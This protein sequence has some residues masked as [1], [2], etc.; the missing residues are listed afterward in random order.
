MIGNW[1]ILNLSEPM[2]YIEYAK[3]Y[4]QASIAM[5][6]RMKENESHCTWSNACVVMMLASH[7]V[8]LFLKGAILAKKSTAN[9]GNHHL[10]YLNAI[11]RETYSDPKYHFEVPFKT[12]CLGMTD[13]E[14]EALKKD[15]PQPSI[16]F[17][18][19][20]WK[21]GVEWEGVYG[22]EPQGFLSLLDSLR[23]NYDRVLAQ[24][25]NICEI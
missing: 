19:P 24:I 6:L 3:A 8:E 9:L 10:E 18:Y 25:R 13:M 11:Y 1:D 14:I 23:E 4:L 15:R 17:R 5:C 21:R 2:R 22:F 7:S 16:L 20:V 12:S